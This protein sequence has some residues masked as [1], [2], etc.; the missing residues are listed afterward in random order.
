LKQRRIFWKGTKKMATV[1]ITQEQFY[2]NIKGKPGK[3]KDKKIF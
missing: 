2:I 1:S 3:V